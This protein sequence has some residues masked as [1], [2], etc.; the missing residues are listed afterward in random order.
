MNFQTYKLLLFGSHTI[1][2]SNELFAGPKHDH[3][4]EEKYKGLYNSYVNL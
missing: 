2:Q 3:E 4:H 1:F